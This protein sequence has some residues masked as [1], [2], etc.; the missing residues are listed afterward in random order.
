LGENRKGGKYEKSYTSSLSV[1]SN[2]VKNTLIQPQRGGEPASG[3]IQSEFPDGNN[4]F[5]IF[6]ENIY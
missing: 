2:E 4:D 6:K 3:F 5:V 1:K